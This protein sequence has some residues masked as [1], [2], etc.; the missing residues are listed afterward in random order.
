[1]PPSWLN[2]LSSLV[3]G[4]QGRDLRFPQLNAEAHTK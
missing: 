4:E 1:M 3:C 2:G